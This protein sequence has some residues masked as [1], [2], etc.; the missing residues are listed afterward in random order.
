M[1]I[2][3]PQHT[4]RFVLAILLQVAI[5]GILILFKFAILSG[6]TQVVLDIAPVDPRD[7][8]RGDY[9]TFTYQNISTISRYQ[10]REPVNPAG[11]GRYSYPI[12]SPNKVEVDVGDTVYVWLKERKR[13]SSRGSMYVTG[14]SVKEPV[15]E[16]QLFIKGTV[17]SVSSGSLFNNSF[18][19][20]QSNNI[21]VSYGI[22]EY[23]IPE[24]SGTQSDLFRRGAQAVV[25]I[26]D[27]GNAVLEYLLIDGEKWP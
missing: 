3:Q 2:E 14:A 24:G 20:N 5:V 22:E 27:E 17:T 23:F 11:T 19:S 21:T 8:L 7:P 4:T 13:G 9:V 15:D 10:L 1:Q 25:K 12:I 6:G 18:R 26:D 16:N